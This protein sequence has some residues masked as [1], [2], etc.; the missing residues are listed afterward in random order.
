MQGFA[1]IRVK[2]IS[3]SGG[4]QMALCGSLCT[5]QFDSVQMVSYEGTSYQLSLA[6]WLAHVC[7]TP[8]PTIFYWLPVKGQ[9]VVRQCLP[10][11]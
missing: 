9:G 6:T 8:A 1:F 11:L 10:L 7:L 3:S 2:C 4:A 5:V